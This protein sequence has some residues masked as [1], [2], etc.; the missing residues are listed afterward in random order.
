PT[1]TARAIPPASAGSTA[2]PPA[3]A[4]LGAP[5]KAA[6]RKPMAPPITSTIK[7]KPMTSRM[8]ARLALSCAARK[9]NVA[10]V[11][12]ASAERDLGRFLYGLP[13][14]ELEHADRLEAELSRDQVGGNALDRVVVVHGGVIVGLP[15]IGHP[16]LGRRELFLKL[17]EVGRRLQIGV[18]LREGEQPPEHAAQRPL[19]LA[20]PR[21]RR[22]VADRA[23]RLLTHP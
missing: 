14:F 5:R 22:R 12:P 13:I 6:T 3:G 1:I 17:H 19:R 23:T 21:H 4:S 15:G 10:T 9:S 20:E 11:F 8:E 18:G 16:V 7:P 2:K